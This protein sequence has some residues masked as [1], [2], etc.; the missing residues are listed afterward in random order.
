MS[1]S[2]SRSLD[3]ADQT[4]RCSRSVV[5][6]SRAPSAAPRAYLQSTVI[7]G[8]STD[9]HQITDDHDHPATQ[10]NRDDR[11]PPLTADCPRISMQNI[12]TQ[13]KAVKK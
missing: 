12:C 9:R 8:Y 7:T 4:Y 2:V 6:L 1:E 11:L 13:H 3:R 5:S 10:Y